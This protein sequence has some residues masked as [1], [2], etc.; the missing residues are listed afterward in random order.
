M[1]VTS[2]EGSTTSEE[3]AQVSD[4]STYKQHAVSFPSLA[5][6]DHPSDSAVDTAYR[7]CRNLRWA[8]NSEAFACN[9][10][11]P[12]SLLGCLSSLSTEAMSFL[13]NTRWVS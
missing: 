3:A 12:L 13:P 2:C 7:P 11:H 9:A 10:E 5:Q 1:L 6:W 8:K 4:L